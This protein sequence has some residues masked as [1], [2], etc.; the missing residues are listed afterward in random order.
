MDDVL[1]IVTEPEAVKGASI[2]LHQ[3]VMR[4]DEDSGR[5]QR[6]RCVCQR[7]PGAV[8]SQSVAHRHA[9]RPGAAMLKYDVCPGALIPDH[10]A[11]RMDI[12]TRCV[13]QEQP[14]T[15]RGPLK[16]HPVAGKRDP[17]MRPEFAGDIAGAVHLQPHA[18]AVNAR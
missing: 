11:P 9:R 1:E 2:V 4:A 5:G 12:I 8:D 7:W 17:D 18:A 10:G 15:R 6:A 13:G 3:R 14:V 16:R